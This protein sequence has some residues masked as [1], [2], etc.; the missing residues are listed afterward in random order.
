MTWLVNLKIYIYQI[1]L[2]TCT[3][4]VKLT[5]NSSGVSY[6]V[7]KVAG[8]GEKSIKFVNVLE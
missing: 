5:L 3:Q 6:I 1:I 2:V 7:Y 8:T 4:I